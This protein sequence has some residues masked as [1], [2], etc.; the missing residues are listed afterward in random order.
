MI[1]SYQHQIDGLEQS[2]NK[3]YYG[4]LYEM[5][6]GKSR[7]ALQTAEY[8]F[9]I[10]KINGLVIVAPKS[11]C[12]NWLHKEIPL[13]LGEATK[14]R[15]VLWGPKTVKLDNEL[16]YINRPIDGKLHIFIVNIETVA[17]N[18]CY[19]EV[20][21]FLTN[22]NSL[23]VIDESTTIKSPTAART[24]ACTK[25]G[26]L[27][28]YR[29][30][31]TGTP[32]TNSPLDVYCQFDFLKYGCLQHKSFYSFRNRYA[33][34]RKRYVS[35]RSFNEIVGYQRLEELKEIMKTCSIR[36]LKRDCLD[37]PEKVYQVRYVEPSI[38]QRRVYELLRAE[39]MA[40]LSNG[41]LIAAPLMIT[42]ILRMRQTLCNTIGQTKVD[43]INPRT[44]EV[45]KILE[46]AGEQ[47]VIIWC[48]FV[49]CIERLQEELWNTYKNQVDCIYGDVP[50]AARQEIV[51]KFQDPQNELKYLIMQ[52][53]TGGFGLTLTAATLVIYYDNDWSLEVRQQT[54]DRCH[55][56]GQK[57]KVTYIDL[58]AAGSIDEKIREALVNKKDLASLINGDNIKELLS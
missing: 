26:R 28:K 15:V 42:Q 36:A 38:E 27:A 49:D 50:A 4:I 29:R 10:G 57:N 18:R 21:R 7:I 53:R 6:L 56:I 8:L 22:H 16:I 40:T 31:L 3:E 13:H 44:E 35:G 5:G 9:G 58:V 2:K 1:T 45:L 33:V 24:K 37:L 48:S 12:R 46:E 54:E 25:L 32:V 52:P 11:I 30:I 51:E 14:R 19:D 41:T 34:M 55:R 39:A 17:G 23:M 47:K 20:E 43:R